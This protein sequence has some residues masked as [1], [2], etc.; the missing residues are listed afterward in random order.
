MH[1]YGNTMFSH[2]RPSFIPFRINNYY[3]K[4][5]YCF[6]FILTQFEIIFIHDNCNL[7][8]LIFGLL[9]VKKAY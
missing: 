5:V 2:L 3:M 1:L 8:M 7:E 9:N 6:F 4:P